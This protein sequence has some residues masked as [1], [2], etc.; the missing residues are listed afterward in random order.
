MPSLSAMVRARWTVLYRDTPQL[1][2]AFS[3]ETVFD[4]VTFIAGP[5]LSVGL[6]VAL[7]PQAG[8]L[9]AA[10]L[11]AIGV[12]ALVVQTGSEPRCRLMT[13]PATSGLR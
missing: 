8:P 1:Q 2:S 6:S 11:L 4:E 7:L 9:A 13:R 10:L 12:F 3:L 5:P